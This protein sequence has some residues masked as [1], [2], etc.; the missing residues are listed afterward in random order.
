MRFQY[1]SE[2]PL[3][4]VE[5]HRV[6]GCEEKGFQRI[7][8]LFLSGAAGTVSRDFFLRFT[9]PGLTSWTLYRS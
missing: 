9:T 8:G 3:D 4:L 5:R 7:Y 6:A 1:S 2:D